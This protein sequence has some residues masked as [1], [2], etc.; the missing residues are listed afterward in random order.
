[1]GFKAFKA[2]N[3][4]ARLN[5]AGELVPDSDADGLTDVYENSIGLNPASKDM[6]G[7]GLGD[8]V[9]LILGR[10]PKVHSANCASIELIDTDSDLLSDCEERYLGSD[11][12]LPDSDADGIL[13]FLEI[14]YDTDLLTHDAAHDNNQDGISNTYEIAV[15]TEPNYA[16]SS[17]AKDRYAYRYSMEYQGVNQELIDCYDF[18]IGN[19]SLVKPMG[20]PGITSGLNEIL[21][22]YIESLL[23]DPE[24]YGQATIGRY[25]AIYLGS[26]YKYPQLGV[27][28]IDD[29]S[30]FNFVSKYF[31]D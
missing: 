5:G 3:L 26:G 20:R 11:D 16:I 30:E 27:I 24:E 14:M 23:D 1:M 7:D 19:I 2:V 25:R 12:Q 28:E 10:D 4:N 13:D 21:I 15:H 22:Y 8:K 31:G 18:T 9:E 29:F 6:D 17:D